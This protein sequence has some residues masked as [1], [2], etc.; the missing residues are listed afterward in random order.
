[1]LPTVWKQKTIETKPLAFLQP[2]CSWGWEAMDFRDWY[3]KYGKVRPIIHVDYRGL[4]F[5]AVGNEMHYSAKWRTFPDF[6]S[7]FII[8]TLSRDGWGSLELKKP[9]GERHPILQWHY[10]LCEYQRKQGKN[11]D[12]IIYGPLTGPGVAY[13]QLAYDLYVVRD[14][15]VLQES[16]LRRLRNTDQFQGARHE[17]MVAGAFI[18]AGFK[19]VLEDEG[20][21]S[22][23]HPEFIAVHK[24]TGIEIDVEAK[25]RRRPGVLGFSGEYNP[26]ELTDVRRLLNAAMAKY[27]GR[28]FC[29][30]LDLNL[31]RGIQGT[32]ERRF[33]ELTE[34]INRSRTIGGKDGDCFNLITFTNFPSY[35]DNNSTSIPCDSSW[36]H[37]LSLKPKHPIAKPEILFEV[38]KA[39]EL[40]GNIPADFE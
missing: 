8:K 20:D 27:R 36:L 34:T 14:N 28:P 3:R 26:S 19:I 31:P 10:S 32:R 24:Q 5:V 17:L 1:M 7:E 30:I 29:I 2:C 4:K 9:L 35:Y 15:M 38:A 18:R 25:S 39:I 22:R 16:L 37:V 12:G 11:Q 13:M 33:A 6:L 21:G 40:F 23:S